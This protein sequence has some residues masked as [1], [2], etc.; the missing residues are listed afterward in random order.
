MALCTLDNVKD[1]YG[2]EGVSDDTLISSLI[3]D[4][5]I[6]FESYCDR[7]FDSTNTLNTLTAAE[8]LGYNL[9]TIL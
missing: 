8:N 6:V 7:T 1:F 5:S 2:I 3:D 9:H 4:V